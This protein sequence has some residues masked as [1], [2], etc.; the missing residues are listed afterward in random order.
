MLPVPW[1][2]LSTWIVSRLLNKGCNV[3]A[4]LSNDFVI[5]EDAENSF[6]KQKAK[7]QW[8]C[9]GDQ[10]SRF[11]HN[12]V[13]KKNEQHTVR[14]LHNVVGSKLETYEE[15]SEKIFQ[16]YKGLIGTV[17][18]NVHGG[19]VQLFQELFQWS[20][21]DEAQ[22]SL[23]QVVIKEEIKAAMFEQ[24]SDKSPGPDGYTSHFFKCA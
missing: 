15:L 23:V 16:F 20:F 8:L 9:E 13:N 24:E 14:S 4:S 7:V 11:F 6:Y 2:I 12:M 10:S 22:E 21:D 3:L 17:D 19:N 5:L 18:S 1:V